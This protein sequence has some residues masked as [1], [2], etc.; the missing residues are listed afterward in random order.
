MLANL[1]LTDSALALSQDKMIEAY[2][3]AGLIYYEQLQ[4]RDLAETQFT[5]AINQPF[6]SDYKLM[7]AFQIYKMYDPTDGK[8]VAQKDYIC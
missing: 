6:E 7:S 4:E 8:A 3:N 2:Y 5:K 1:P